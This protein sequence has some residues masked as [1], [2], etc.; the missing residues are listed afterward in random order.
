[1]DVVARSRIIRARAELV[2]G[3]PFFAALA[4]RLPLHEDTQCRC[5]WTDG[6]RLAYNPSRVC[7]LPLEQLVGVLGHEVLH[8]AC[9]HHL[10]R[11]GRDERLW[12]TACDH[13]INW[14]CLDAGLKLPDGYVDDPD[15]R[16]LPVEEIYARLLSKK[17]EEQHGGAQSSSEGETVEAEDA[18]AAA[19]DSTNTEETEEPSAA[20][21]GDQDTPDGEGD[22]DGEATDKPSGSRSDDAQGN[23]SAGTGEVRDPATD[24]GAGGEPDE[25]LRDELHQ[26]L[27]QAEMAV[28]DM[29]DLPAGIETILGSVLRPPLPWKELLA[30][31][32]EANARNDYSW[33]P[34]NRRYL[35]MGLHLP[36]LR[37]MELPDIVVAIDTSGSVRR[38]ELD[39]FAAELSAI[40]EDFDTT[41]HLFHCDAEVSHHET[42]TQ[43]DLP[44]HITAR[45]GGGT[46][47]RP[48]FE[49]VERHGLAPACLVYL[50]DMEC[51]KFPEAPPYPVL[52]VSTLA[53]EGKPP[54]GELITM[55]K[56]ME[57]HA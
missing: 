26:M 17:G 47:F 4:L 49:H 30:R 37:T 9:G 15:L 36:E 20:P 48:V 38:A 42:L 21:G 28:R 46:D 8:V 10:R 32:I 53:T 35:H 19:G 41:V 40:L 7:S 33:I 16:N 44:L 29:G 12:N 45:G 1:M 57:P 13:A 18:Q 22:G 55:P 11:Q 23:D 3:H 50:S 52:W 31:F 34:P 27:V 6:T 2:L 43:C 54:F 24:D 39:A 25:L 51:N 14:I 56:I 5:A